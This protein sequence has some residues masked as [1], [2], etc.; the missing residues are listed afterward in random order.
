MR[1]CP[2]DP[3][4][5][6]HG[7]VGAQGLMGADTDKAASPF[8]LPA[9]GRA[10][11]APTRMRGS[12]RRFWQLGKGTAPSFPGACRHRA[13]GRASYGPMGCRVQGQLTGRQPHSRARSRAELL[14][15][16]GI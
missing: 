1:A 12:V 6:K 10:A 11:P 14:P 7:G 9:H 16:S 3:S 4:S 2:P 8:L 5:A 13:L 15:V